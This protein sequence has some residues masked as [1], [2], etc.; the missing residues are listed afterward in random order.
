MSD[1][2][3]PDVRMQQA[4]AEAI[5]EFGKDGAGAGTIPRTLPRP[6]RT[7]PRLVIEPTRKKRRL[8]MFLG[9]LLLVAGGVRVAPLLSRPDAVPTEIVGTWT[10][11]DLRYEGRRLELTRDTLTLRSGPAQAT[12]YAVESVRRMPMAQGS[13][14]IITTHSESAGDYIL[15][16]EYHEAQKTIA[17]GKPARGLWRR[18]R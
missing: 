8:P 1:E 7:L 14:Y 12:E 3:P 16:L 9:L 15:M 5:R 6:S 11:D 2:L 18:T 13:A 17:L 10:T 4:L